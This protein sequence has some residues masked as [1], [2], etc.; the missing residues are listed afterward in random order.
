MSKEIKFRSWDGNRM[1]FNSPNG[2]Y[3]FIIDGGRVCTFNEFDRGIKVR[4]WPLMQST[5]LKDK[6]GTDI[7]EGDVVRVIFDNDIESIHKV[8][9]GVKD[10]GNGFFSY[11]P[12]YC[13]EPS[14]D[15]EINDFSLIFDSGEYIIEVVGNIY[16]NQLE[17]EGHE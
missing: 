12:A 13:L 16:E 4:D 6:S 8:V 9:W 14:F 1:K 11:Y 2:Y 17:G 5:G 3:D 7:Y 15:I 10:L